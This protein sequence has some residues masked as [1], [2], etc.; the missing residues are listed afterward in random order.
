MLC[1]SMRLQ[2]D[3]PKL[4]TAL[5]DYNLSM[6][7][8][9]KSERVEVVKQAREYK[10]NAPKFFGA[11]YS[12]NDLL[13]RR[14]D[15]N[16]V[17]FINSFENY[18][19]GAHGMYGWYGVNFDSETGRQ[20]TISDVCTDAE[21]LIVAITKRLYADYDDRHFDNLN[22]TLVKLIAQDEINFVIEPRG[23]TFIFNPY[24][25]APYAAGLITATLFFDEHP[26]LFKDKYR[27]SLN[28]YAQSVPIFLPTTID[29]NGS[30]A[31]LSIS[32]EYDRCVVRLNNQMIAL[33]LTDVHE[34]TYVHTA[35]GKNFLYIDGVAKVDGF[36][37]VDG[38]CISLLKL[39]GE[40]EL[41]DRM[42]YTFR[43]LIDRESATD[44][45][46]W[47]LMTNPNSMQFDS[48]RPIG[49]LHSHFG[50]VSDDGTF[51]FG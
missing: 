32:N 11:F 15:S 21:K 37:G 25:V 39:D 28:A 1:F 31:T 35:D 29:R 9:A 38:E 22:D 30:R 49:D 45:T 5:S 6:I 44:E 10:Q 24:E 42:P 2:S 43:H 26:Q 14:A 48:S 47:W 3:Y 51:S 40:L 27:Q 36:S 8:A 18:S 16:V 4:S 17:S 19:G 50:A 13:M 12:N 23:V 7:N 34:A 33:A 41:Y 20:L 46:E